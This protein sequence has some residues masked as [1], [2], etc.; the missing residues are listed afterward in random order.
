MSR[1]KVRDAREAETCLAAA[2]ASGL[3]RARWAEANGVDARSLNAWRLNLGRGGR[4]TEVRFVEM[5]ARERIERSALYVVRCGD[6]GIE[7][8]ELF[9][10][11]VLRRLIG[12]V[13]SC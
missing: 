9:D 4:D 12:V 7:V 5:V 13:A 3:S 2:A 11:D 6:L 10:D 8:D 1:R